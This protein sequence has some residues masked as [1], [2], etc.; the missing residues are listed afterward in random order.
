MTSE[1]SPASENEA[2]SK[3]IG[4]IE[5][6]ITA[7]KAAIRR[8]SRVRLVVLLLVVAILGGTIFAFYNLGKQIASQENLDLLETKARARINES[9]DKVIKNV[10]ALVEHCQP[11]LKE[12]F[13]A[14]VE[15]DKA[16][17]TALF[18]AE[19][20]TLIANLQDELR[21]KTM[22]RQKEMEEQYQAIIREEFPDLD[23][24]LAVQMYE[25]IAQIMLKLADKYY[26]TQLQDEL[27]ELGE[28]WDEF[29]MADL[30]AEGEHSLQIQ[31]VASLLQLAADKLD[32]MPVKKL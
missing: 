19:K 20:A 29:D 4:A 12:A 26:S 30:P 6:E 8:A 7:V 14:Q 9:S 15:K 32:N 24:D 3:K 10:N 23:D 11:I 16:K 17:Y 31:L 1:N 28:T 27:R 25:N 18:E 22:A 2:L 21:E 5:Q 13:A